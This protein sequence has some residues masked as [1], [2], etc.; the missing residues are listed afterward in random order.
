MPLHFCSFDSIDV[1]E[2]D[3]TLSLLK[4]AK[5]KKQD[6][7]FLLLLRLEAIDDETQQIAHKYKRQTK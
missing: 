2:V 4:S 6:I 1:V 7:I 5:S 3:A